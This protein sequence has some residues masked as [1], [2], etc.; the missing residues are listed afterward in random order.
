MKKLLVLLLCLAMVFSFAACGDK[1]GD[2]PA[3]APDG[4]DE[5]AGD[6]IEITIGHTDSS[7]RS[8]NVWGVWLGDQLSAATDGRITVT[9]GPDG[10]FGDDPDIAAGVKIGT[11]TM[12]FGL[13]S[14]ISSIVGDQAS[15]VDLPYLYTT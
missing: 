4:G 14:V 9:M 7:E 2:T 8:T 6:P 12:Y 1:G 3:P 5:P 13:A 10:Q 15:C 11:V